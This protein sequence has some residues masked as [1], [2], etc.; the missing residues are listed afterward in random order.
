MLRVCPSRDFGRTDNLKPYLDYFHNIEKS[1]ISLNGLFLFHFLAFKRFFRT[2]FGEV[3]ISHCVGDNFWSPATNHTDDYV[4]LVPSFFCTFVH[5]LLSRF[6]IVILR[7]HPAR[8]IRSSYAQT[9]Q[10]RPRYR[11][12]ISYTHVQVYLFVRTFLPMCVRTARLTSARA[13]TYT[14]MTATKAAVWIT[15][16]LP[17]RKRLRATVGRDSRKCLFGNSNNR[18]SWELDRSEQFSPF[19]WKMK[20]TCIDDRHEK[21]RIAWW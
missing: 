9:V 3:I 14:Y 11:R 2:L 18:P 6:S 13:H 10:H 12:W 4:Y 21:L 16:R 19:R 1:K 17:M 20:T 7:S 15:S 5:T 8:D